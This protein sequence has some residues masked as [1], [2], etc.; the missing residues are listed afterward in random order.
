MC[1]MLGLRMSATS[2][3][4]WGREHREFRAQIH[5]RMRHPIATAIERERY[6]SCDPGPPLLQYPRPSVLPR[7]S[8]MAL[9]QTGADRAHVWRG[10]ALHR[11]YL[12]E[13]Y[14][15]SARG[16]AS[17]VSEAIAF[18][19]RPKSRVA[20]TRGNMGSASSSPHSV[21][22]EIT[23]PLGSQ[24]RVAYRGLNMTV[25]EILLNGTGVDP[26][27]REIKATGMAEHRGMDREGE[28]S[29]AP[30]AQQHMADGAIA[31]GAPPL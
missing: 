19:R 20:V 1:L 2:L 11:K 7:S 15:D 28:L 12:S 30:S 16:T 24:F 14:D 31:E 21:I 27:V 3:A 23:K 25:P 26:F 18:P 10:D 29:V 6:G 5:L 9:F 17:T 22:P 13:M 4:W 8:R